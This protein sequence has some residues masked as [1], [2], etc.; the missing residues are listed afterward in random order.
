MAE[1]ERYPTV[2]VEVDFFFFF[3]L[4]ASLAKEFDSIGHSGMFD[5]P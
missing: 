2:S 1:P 5:T 4:A 3:L